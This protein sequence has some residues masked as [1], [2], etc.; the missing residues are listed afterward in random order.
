VSQHLGWARVRGDALLVSDQTNYKIGPHTDAAHRLITFLYYLPKDNRFQQCGTG[1]Y[2]PKDPSFTCKGDRHHSFEPFILEKTIP[3]TP[4]KL[5][6][7]VRTDRSF[8]GVETIEYE[9]ITRRLL[10]NNIRLV[11]V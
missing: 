5:L 3:F 11:D 8:H 2:S 9:D 10:I 6:I 1:I 7:F 4:N